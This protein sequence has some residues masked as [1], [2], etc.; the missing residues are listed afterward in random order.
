MLN[1]KVEG[2]EARIRQEIGYGKTWWT[3]ADNGESLRD[4]KQKKNDQICNA[5]FTGLA[6]GEGNSFRSKNAT[7]E[8]QKDHVR[9]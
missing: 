3:R 2:K 9:K 6:C 7:L 1:H 5:E 8:I 4:F